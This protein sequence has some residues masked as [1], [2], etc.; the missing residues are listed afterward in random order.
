MRRITIFFQSFHS[1]GVEQIFINLANEL[2]KQN[3]VTAM[4]MKSE[5]E[6]KEDLDPKISIVDLDK[7]KASDTI[8]PMMKYIKENSPDLMI[9]AKHFMNLSA[10]LAKLMSGRKM[11]IISTVHGQL[12]NNK[13]SSLMKLLMKGLYPYADAVVCV[14]R[15]VASEVKEILPSK[16]KGKVSVIYNPVI[17]HRFI[18]KSNEMLDIPL[19]KEDNEKWIVS[20]G[21]L[22]EEKNLQMLIKAYHGLGNRHNA[23]L[24][25]IGNGPEKEK[26]NQLVFKLGLEKEVL[27]KGFQK[28]PYPYLKK[29]DVF[30][31]SSDREGL[32]TVLIEA[33][34]FKVPIISTD[35]KSGPREILKD[36]KYGVLVPT[37]NVDKMTLALE[38]ALT[39]KSIVE[40]NSEMLSPYTLETV[41]V[42]YNRLIEDIGG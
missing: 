26:L 20:I 40:V 22:S 14:S 23:K 15:G 42:S 41:M 39:E 28:N 8:L 16:H 2:S 27:F 7:E 30:V 3:E 34:Y 25:I 18:L 33:L 36:G 1:G 19:V 31:L 5:G 11:K 21:R 10:L 4:V 12:G 38:K 9:T 29:A 32:P 37:N 13:K 35:C 6:L 17:D 24:L